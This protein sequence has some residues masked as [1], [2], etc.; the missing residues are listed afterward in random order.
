MVVIITNLD[1]MGGSVTEN[2]GAESVE[3]KNC[4]KNKT[5]F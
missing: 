3:N 5:Q 1:M 2:H 4:I